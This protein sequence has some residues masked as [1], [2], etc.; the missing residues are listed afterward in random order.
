MSPCSSGRSGFRS[1]DTGSFN[2]I[3]RAINPLVIV[4]LRYG[5]MV[6]RTDD[7]TRRT[8]GVFAVCRVVQPP[9]RL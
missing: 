4:A 8:S 6:R 2:P 9:Q 5:R 7:A 1:L 3:A